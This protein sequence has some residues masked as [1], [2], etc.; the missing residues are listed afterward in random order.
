[1]LSEISW[2]THSISEQHKNN[3]KNVSKK[4]TQKNREI[5]CLQKQEILHRQR[6]QKS[7]KICLFGNDVKIQN[8][9]K[10]VFWKKKK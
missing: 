3:Q 7:K 1:M 5:C 9:Q 8:F 10:P 4:L 6:K 2:H